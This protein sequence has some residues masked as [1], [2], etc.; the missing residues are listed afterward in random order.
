MTTYHIRDVDNRVEGRLALV[1]GARYNLLP[2]FM[3]HSMLTISAVE[4]V[5]L[6][7]RL[8]QQRVVMSCSIATP[9]W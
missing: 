5:Q 6:L 8:W 7:P 4:S 2:T 3:I 1:T 9:V